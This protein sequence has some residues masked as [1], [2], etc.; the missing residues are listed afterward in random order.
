ME[1]LKYRNL[2]NKALSSL[3]NDEVEYNTNLLKGKNQWNTAKKLLKIQ[4]TKNLVKIINNNKVI[5]KPQ[6][7][8]EI[9]NEFYIN[10]PKIIEEKIKKVNY[11]PFN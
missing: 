3:K 6:E 11:K 5:T 8:S 1:W 10:K 7:I 4:P 2:R 9:M